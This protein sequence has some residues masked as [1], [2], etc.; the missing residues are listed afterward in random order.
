M[1]LAGARVSEICGVPDVCGKPRTM[2]PTVVDYAAVD[3]YYRLLSMHSKLAALARRHPWLF[4][5]ITV[6]LLG[7]IGFAMLGTFFS[8]LLA[9]PWPWGIGAL[10]VLFFLA[11]QIRGA[12]LLREMPDK[13]TGDGSGPP[14]LALSQSNRTTTN[15]QVKQPP[16]E[17]EVT[18]F[19]HLAD[20]IQWERD[21]LRT[22]NI[23]V[24]SLTLSPIEQSKMS[25]RSAQLHRQLQ[26]LGVECP[27]RNHEL[28][29]DFFIH[30]YHLATDGNLAE[31]RE[32]LP[33]MKERE[34]KKKA[35][36]KEAEEQAQSE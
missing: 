17:V 2:P 30:L 26:D 9:S 5:K 28:W 34:A 25:R 4:A 33:A 19:R 36:Q 24:Y 27:A 32:L 20:E 8:G 13:E 3:G 31:A 29:G 11:F 21:T 14:P 7:E 6:I 16:D 22:L 23:F 12:Q 10:V 15:T 1:H 18:R 35:E